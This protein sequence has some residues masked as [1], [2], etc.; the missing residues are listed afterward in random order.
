MA[1]TDADIEEESIST[2]GNVATNRANM[3]RRNLKGFSSFSGADN[4]ASTSMKKDM[5]AQQL[6]D[7]F[8]AKVR[9]DEPVTL[10][11][12]ITTRYKPSPKFDGRGKSNDWKLFWQ[13]V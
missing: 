10:T 2:T 1:A 7:A 12:E 5:L 13:A 4:D 9:R 6:R 8:T 3:Q 11:H